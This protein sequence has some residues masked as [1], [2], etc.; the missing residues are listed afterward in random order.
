MNILNNGRF[1]MSACLSGTMR[2]AIEKA[3]DHAINRSQFGNKI[4]SYGTIQEKLV[5]MCMA[6]YITEVRKVINFICF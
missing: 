4:H 1:G 5:R 3:T 6:Q 2:L